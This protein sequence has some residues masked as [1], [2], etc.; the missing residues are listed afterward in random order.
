[1]KERRLFHYPP[2]TRLIYIYLKHK[3]D[4]IV[5]TASIELGSRLRQVFAER[6]LGPDKPP[7]ARVKTLNIRK[8]M[9]KLETTLSI[10]STRSAIR[11]A[12]EGMMQDA[13]YKSLLIYYDVDP[14]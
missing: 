9:L 5:N 2:F 7:V 3:D 14:E 12:V 1:M 13:C 4:N 11:S 8:I 6:V 10:S